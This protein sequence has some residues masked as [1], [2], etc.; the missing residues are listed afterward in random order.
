MSDNEGFTYGWNGADQLS[1]HSYLIPGLMDQLTRFA[2]PGDLLLDLGAGNGSVSAEI[3]RRGYG[4]V[5][6]EGSADGVAVARSAW[7]TIR[8]EQYW[9]GDPLPADLR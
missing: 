7:P 1:Q 5:G 6:L 4:V 3:D 9:I 8:F 2:K